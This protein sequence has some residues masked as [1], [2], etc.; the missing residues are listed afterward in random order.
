VEIEGPPY[1]HVRE[2]RGTNA[3]FFH[4]ANILP[5]FPGQPFIRLNFPATVR[6]RILTPDRNKIVYT[7]DRSITL[8]VKTYAVIEITD[9]AIS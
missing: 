1:I 8:E 4:C 3:A 5:G 2:Y 6:A 9:R 7:Q